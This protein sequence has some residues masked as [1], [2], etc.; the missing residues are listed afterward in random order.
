MYIRFIGLHIKYIQIKM[1]NFEYVDYSTT[2]RRAW[3][4][5]REIHR[6]KL[7]DIVKAPSKTSKTPLPHFISDSKT[8]KR[9]QGKI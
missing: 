1:K 2:T 3:T 6:Q 9:Q 5:A 4:R 7:I 8:R